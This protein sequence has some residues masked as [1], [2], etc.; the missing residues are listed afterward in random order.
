[1]AQWMV[2]AMLLGVNGEKFHIVNLA[3]YCNQML[4]ADWD[5][6]NSFAGLIPG[7]RWVL[8]VPFVIVDPSLNMGKAVVRDAEIPVNARANFVFALLAN[9]QQNARLILRFADGGEQSVSLAEAVPVII[10]HPPL[11]SWHLDMIVVK[12]GHAARD[13]GRVIKSVQVKGADLF[14]LTL[15]THSQEEIQETLMALNRKLEQWQ[16]EQKILAQ[17]RELREALSPLKGRVAVLPVPPPDSAQSHPLFSLLSR[18]GLTEHWVVLSPSQLVDETF[19]VAQRFPVVFY[20]SG[21]RFYYTVGRQ[22]DAVDAV[23]KFL[24]DGGLLLIFASQPFPFFYDQ[25]G[26]PIGNAEAFGLPVRGGWERP[27]QNVKLAFHR[28]PTQDIVTELPET[29][30]FPTEGDLR[31]RPIFKPKGTEG[32]DFIYTPILTL[33]DDK[34]NEYGDGAAVLEYRKGDFALGRLVYVWHTLWQTE[35]KLPLLRGLLRWAAQTVQERPP[36]AQTIVYRTLK[37]IR[38]DGVLDEPE[39]QTASPLELKDIKGRNAPKTFAR[40]LWDDRYIYIA[41]ECSDD[42]IWATKTQRDDFL[43]EEEVVE[44]FIDPDGD[45]LNYYEFQVNPLGTEIDLLIPDAIEGV[46]HAKKNAEWNCQGWLSAVK[47]RGTVNK[48]D[49]QDDGWTVEM[50]IPISEIAPPASLVQRPGISWRLNLYRIERPKG[51]E[52]EP[53][54]LSWS[55]CVIWFH[56]P[57]RF[58]RVTFAGNPYD[59]DFK[60]YP[61]GSDGRP[62]WMPLGGEWRMQGGVYYGVDG[63]ADG[64]IALGSKS[65]FDWWRNYEVAVRFRVL[66]FGSDWRDGFWLGFRW[67]DVNNAYSLNF[68]HG[69]GGVVHL[70][71]A[72]NGISTGDNNPIA[73]ARWTPDNEWHE[74]TVRIE[75]NRIIAWLDGKQLLSAV[76]ENFNGVPQVERGAIILSPRRWSQSKGHTR[77]AISK[78]T[79]RLLD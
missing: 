38:I 3:P 44:A 60:L 36:I 45:G 49:D 11:Y 63:G 13:K 48:R 19:F 25:S 66:E 40:L 53:L 16:M 22:N 5:D 35:V 26:K 64:W 39:W 75:G 18:A 59:D 12:V 37:P 67:L 47:V 2:I 46:K 61:D 57:E 79:I 24:Y 65:G 7:K 73:S 58:A 29:I 20:L 8:G 55:K 33:R 68:Y 28:N 62:T 78:V 77:V 15:S 30:P 1:M 14:A 10:A 9:A 54:L 71:K 31:W 51:K 17:L 21:E 76:D 43:W 32:V 52:D 56:E 50:A 23:R 6:T 69:Q 4:H 70:H 34:G 72:K 74:V 27:P 41:F 42:D